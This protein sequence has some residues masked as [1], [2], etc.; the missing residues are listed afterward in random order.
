MSRI[1]S[2]SHPDDARNPLARRAVETMR[3]MV[4]E[5]VHDPKRLRG[6][7]GAVKWDCGE[8]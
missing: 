2:A 3:M 1:S 7:R 6:A 8:I 5:E 4:V